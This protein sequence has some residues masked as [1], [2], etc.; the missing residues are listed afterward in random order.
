MR[1]DYSTKR[2]VFGK[3]LSENP[4]HLRTMAK[5]VVQLRWMTHL[6]FHVI[7]LL[8]QTESPQNSSTT[9][10]TDSKLLLR[11]FTPILKATTAKLGVAFLSDCMECLGGQ[12]YV[13][14]GGIAVLYRDAQVNTIWEGTTNVLADDMLRVLRGKTGAETLDALDRYM[15]SCV[16]QGEKCTK[17]GDC[18]R[19]FARMYQTWRGRVTQTDGGV[20]TANARELAMSLGRIV[21]AMETMVDAASDGDDVEVECCKRILD[22]DHSWHVDAKTTMTWDKRIIFGDNIPLTSVVQARL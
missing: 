2:K 16:E 19:G 9:D 14:E 10:I 1:Q 12:G 21:G 18:A 4:L 7:S 17:L 15:A 5:L 20:V 22:E 13:E 11:L 8:G 6:L 3:L